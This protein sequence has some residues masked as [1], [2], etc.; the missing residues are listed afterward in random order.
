M[1]DDVFG[2]KKIK[3]LERHIDKLNYKID[4]ISNELDRVYKDVYGRSKQVSG[5]SGTVDYTFTP[6]WKKKDA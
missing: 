1:L 6:V 4:Y 5:L 3:Q 2:K